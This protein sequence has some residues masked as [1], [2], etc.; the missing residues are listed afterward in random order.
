MDPDSVGAVRIR[1]LTADAGRIL[2]VCW[3]TAAVTT[4]ANVPPTGHA[5]GERGAD[6]TRSAGPTGQGLL[7]RSRRERP[8]PAT[9]SFDDCGADPRSRLVGCGNSGSGCD[10]RLSLIYAACLYSLIRPLR[11]SS[12]F[13]RTLSNLAAA[14]AARQ[15]PYRG[16]PGDHVG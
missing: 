2:A 1:P 8:G 10:L 6:R 14:V 4:Q 13:N 15:R 12:R 9:Q 11:T 3:R 16:G 7:P 5:L